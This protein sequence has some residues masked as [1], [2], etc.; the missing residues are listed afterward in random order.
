MKFGIN[1]YVTEDNWYEG[2]FIPKN[3][4]IMINSWALN[5]DED[6]F[7]NPEKVGPNPLDELTIVR[8][9]TI[10]KPQVVSRRICC[11]S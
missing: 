4:I 8:A 11:N 10:H 7:P 1:H 2:F 9:G 5:Y 6:V 3:T